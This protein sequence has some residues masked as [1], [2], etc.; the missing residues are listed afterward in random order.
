MAGVLDWALSPHRDLELSRSRVIGCWLSRSLPG[1]L[2]VVGPAFDQVQETLPRLLAV[3]AGGFGG[4]DAATPAALGTSRSCRVPFGS[5]RR[6]SDIHGR[7]DE[8]QG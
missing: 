8:I 2:E 1:P 5:S 6:L 4:Q 7:E 3:V